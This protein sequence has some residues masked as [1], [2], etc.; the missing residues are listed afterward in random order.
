MSKIYD[1]QAK[2]R[3]TMSKQIEADDIGMAARLA[4]ELKWNDFFADDFYAE[5]Q[6]EFEIVSIF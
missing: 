1:I 2:I 6:D 3:V 4:S 5:G